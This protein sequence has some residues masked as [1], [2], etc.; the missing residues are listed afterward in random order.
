MFIK[1]SVLRAA[2]ASLAAVALLAAQP[3]RAESSSDT[4]RIEKLERAVELLAKQ[5]AELQAEIKSLKKETASGLCAAAGSG[6]EAG[7]WWIHPDEFR[8]RRCLRV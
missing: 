7:A 6:I 2:G 1:K 5:N 4:T 3:L 8:R